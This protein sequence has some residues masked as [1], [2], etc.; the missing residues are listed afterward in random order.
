GKPVVV[1]AF[2]IWEKIVQET[3]CGA[4]VASIDPEEIA[5]QIDAI[6]SDAYKMSQMGASGR[7]AIEKKYNWEK[8]EKTLIECYNRLLGKTEDSR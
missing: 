1:S 2:P 3:G 8:E 7:R 5:A 6:Y 4:T